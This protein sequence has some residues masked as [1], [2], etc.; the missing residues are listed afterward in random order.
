MRGHVRKRGSTWTI[1]WRETSPLT[2]ERRQRSKGGYTSEPE[3][4]VALARKVIELEDVGPLVPTEMTVEQYARSWL[5]GRRRLKAGT[6]RYYLSHIN[7]RIVPYVGRL[8][9]TEVNPDHLRRMLVKLEEDGLSSAYINDVFQTLRLLLDAAVTE[10][11]IRAN[12]ARSKV[13]ELPRIRRK[14]P[15]IL[16]D[17][18]L[19]RFIDVI[20]GHKHE[21]LFRFLLAS[22]VRIGEAL[23]LRWRG[24]DFQKHRITITERYYSETHDVA[25]PKSD[26]GGRTLH[27]DQDT[28]RL[29]LGHRDRQRFN[30]RHVDADALV[31]PG[32]RG[33]MHST[34]IRLALYEIQRKHDF[35][36]FSP[37]VLRHTGATMLLRRGVPVHIV[38]RRLGHANIRVTLEYYAHW[39]P[40]DD[41]T[42]AAVMGDILR[43]D[44]EAAR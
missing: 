40:A 17:D 15:E 9:V 44:A 33:H 41:L 24:V 14:R 37:H 5:A 6:R 27:L 32:Q 25:A 43:G 28:I 13:L 30:G 38:S 31:F 4:H 11:V 2:G 39:L 35:H 20:A 16:D 22:Q 3:A 19:S 8:A 7:R 18:E 23:A 12:P 26:A 1:Y 21:M 10:R 36:H 34:T 29:L 42:V